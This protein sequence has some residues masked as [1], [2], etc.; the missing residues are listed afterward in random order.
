MIVNVIIP[1]FDRIDLIKRTIDSLRHCPYQDK[2]VWILVDGN[3]EI[4]QELREYAPYPE[5]KF[6]FNKRRRDVVASY[7]KI[8]K[9][10]DNDGAILHASDD[11]IFYSET[12]PTAVRVLKRYFS[13]TDGVI[14]LNQFQEGHPRVRL[15]AFCLTGRKF[16]ERYKKNK[17]FCPDYVHFNA[18]R[19]HGIFAKSFH[20]YHFCEEARFIHIRIPDKTTKIGRVNYDRDNRMQRERRSRKLLWGLSF[21]LIAK[22]LKI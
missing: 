19:E 21:K 12:I 7:N 18:D 16:Y 4:L 17:M 20:K 6:L 15:F 5:F 2:I 14:G 1:T 3:L 22:E 13:D 9:A 11:L 8:V 10:I